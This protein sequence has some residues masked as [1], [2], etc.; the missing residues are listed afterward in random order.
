[1][2]LDPADKTYTW[3]KKGS[4]ILNQVLP[5]HQ[6]HPGVAHYIIHSVDYPSLAEL[7]L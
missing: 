4:A 5:R 6:N 2:Y 3:Q 1:L 7:G